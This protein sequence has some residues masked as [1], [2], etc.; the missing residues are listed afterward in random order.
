MKFLTLNTHSWM[1][2]EPEEKFRLLLQDILENSYDLICFQEI[3]Q[4]ITSAHQRENSAAA[5][6]LKYSPR[7]RQQPHRMHWKMSPAFPGGRSFS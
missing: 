1:E 7:S 6:A 4:E 3:N 5:S 2:K